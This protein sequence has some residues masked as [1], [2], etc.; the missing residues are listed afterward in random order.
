MIVLAIL[1]RLLPKTPIYATLVTQSVSGGES[2]AAQEKAHSA[3]VGREGVALSVLRP[4]GKAQF[5]DE[6]LDVM[7]QGELI[8]KGARV[9]IVAH[10]GREAVVE[11]IPS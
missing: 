3:Q 6:V 9:R 4:G 10:S 5:G 7:T 1:A 11:A 8:E 2:P